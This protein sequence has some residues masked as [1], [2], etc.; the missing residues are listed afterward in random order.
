MEKMEK[1]E[2]MREEMIKK[3]VMGMREGGRSSAD[4][5]QC[6]QLVDTSSMKGNEESDAGY[7]EGKIPIVILA[8]LIGF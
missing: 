2:K 5:S 8:K 1:M 6:L 3:K 7:H 4:K